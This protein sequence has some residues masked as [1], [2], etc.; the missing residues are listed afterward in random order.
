MK[1]EIREVTALLGSTALLITAAVLIAVCCGCTRTVYEPV[2]EV[3][4]EY[5]E[6]DTMAIYNRLLK[7]FESR[8]ET[9]TRSDSLVDRQKETVVLKE[10]GDTARYDKERIIYRATN[11]EKELEV[12]NKTLRDSVS[13]L[14]TRLVS[15]KT[16]SVPSIVPVERELSRWEQIKI[17]YGGE[18]IVAVAGLLCVAVIWLIRKFRK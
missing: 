12:E 10:N 3:R 17:D 5:K 8:R 1:S 7:L 13:V 2:V 6:A 11:R 14:N 9:E 15:I 4:T 18:A 16:D